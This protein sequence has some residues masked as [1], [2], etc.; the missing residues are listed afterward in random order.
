MNLVQ[1]L[2]G[3]EGAVDSA[4]FS[5]MTN[6]FNKIAIMKLDV[7]D[8]IKEIKVLKNDD[9]INLPGWDQSTFGINDYSKLPI[10]AVKYIEFLEGKLDVEISIISTGPERNQTIFKS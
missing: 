1:Q 3:K 5:I 9:Y 10:N 6:G 2:A 4:Y 8:G 7:L